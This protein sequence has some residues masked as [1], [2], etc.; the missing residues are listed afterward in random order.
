MMVYAHY[1][2]DQHVPMIVPRSAYPQVVHHLHRS[3]T[4]ILNLPYRIPDN[5]QYPT[6][7]PVL[8]Q[9]VWHLPPQLRRTGAEQGDD[10]GILG[11]QQTA[12]FR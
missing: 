9:G 11:D 7:R 10:R 2:R 8:L 4:L 12:L 5:I 6:H 3:R 1:Q